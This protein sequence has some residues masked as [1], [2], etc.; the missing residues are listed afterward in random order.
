MFV[1]FGIRREFSRWGSENIFDILSLYDNNFSREAVLMEAEYSERRFDER[2][3]KSLNAEYK[4]FGED[5]DLL[6]YQYNKA[7]TKDISKKGV[8]LLTKNIVR[9]GDV[10][11]LD[12]EIE[13]RKKINIFGEVKWCMKDSEGYIA[14][15]KFISPSPRDTETLC[16]LF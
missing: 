2:F 9:E 14:G 10:M 1:E 4:V 16:E 6:S 3:K 13:V 8:C 11:R 7:G 15:I 12:I 5:F